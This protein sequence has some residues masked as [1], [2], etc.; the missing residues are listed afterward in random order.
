MF[1]GTGATAWPSAGS[2]APK[3]KPPATAALRFKNS[4]RSVFLESMIFSLS[5]EAY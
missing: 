2:T 5:D 3:V 4:R 1:A